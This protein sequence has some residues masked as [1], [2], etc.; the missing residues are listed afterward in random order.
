MGGDHLIYMYE[1]YGNNTKGKILLVIAR[2][3][4]A[5]MKAKF[6]EWCWGDAIFPI[7]GSDGGSAKLW[8]NE[9]PYSSGVSYLIHLTKKYE[10]LPQNQP[11]DPWGIEFG[12]KK[13]GN[14]CQTHVCESLSK[15]VVTGNSILSANNKIIL[16][17][18][19][20][21]LHEITIFSY[22]GR[23]V[24]SQK[25]FCAAGKTSLT[26]ESLTPGSYL[27]QVEGVSGTFTSRLILSF[28]NNAMNVFTEK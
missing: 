8:D 7:V 21:G 11:Y 4:A 19:R 15:P 24:L 18:D 12:M 6:E 26:I 23:C 20:T 17:V 2:E 5:Q 9:Y 13:A 25:L 16:T 14:C 1:K 3:T 28:F 22:S 10:K 27:V